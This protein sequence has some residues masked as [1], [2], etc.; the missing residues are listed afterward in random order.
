MTR[1]GFEYKPYTT[2]TVHYTYLEKGE[3]VKHDRVSYAD[4]EE[5]AIA[6]AYEMLLI[7]YKPE[8]HVTEVTKKEYGKGNLKP[9]A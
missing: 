1:R 5:A 2:Y 3:W 9:P 7:T 8:F 4:S 6:E